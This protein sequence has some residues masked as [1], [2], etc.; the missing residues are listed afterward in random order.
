MT[1]LGPWGSAI[2]DFLGSDPIGWSYAIGQYGSLIESGAV[3]Y[4]VAPW[5]TGGNTEEFTTDTGITFGSCSKPITAVAMMT[6]FQS[7]PPPLNWGGNLLI[8]LDSTVNVF[9]SGAIS[10][11]GGGP[12]S[13]PGAGVAGVTIGQLLTMFAGMSPQMALTEDYLTAMESFV[14]SACQTV[15]GAAYN[16]VNGNFSIMQLVLAGMQGSTDYTQYVPYVLDNVFAP[17]GITAVQDAPF[18]NTLTYSPGQSSGTGYA[19]PQITSST[20]CGGWCGTVLDLASFLMGIRNNLV[21][22]AA[23]AQLMFN[24]GLGWYPWPL[25]DGTTAW[26][27]S[28][29]ISNAASPE[30]GLMT[31]IMS[32]PNGYDAAWICNT[33]SPWTWYQCLAY[34]YNQVVGTTAD[35]HKIVKPKG[36]DE[37]V[38]LHPRPR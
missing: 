29:G 27:H 30:Q 22:T 20:A 2:Q 26:W 9:T 4:A 25:D 1:S 8:M 23:N 18:F 12:A 35:I 11:P 19:V 10:D 21:L 24:L 16:Y 36:W 15:P 34:A 31:M 32:M 38:R 33:Y 6:L 37:A 5:D 13:D 3:G 7:P 28:G 14:Q 17:M